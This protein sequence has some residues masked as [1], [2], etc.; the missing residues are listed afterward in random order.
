MNSLEE[1]G[2]VASQDT[3]IE[4]IKNRICKI[5]ETQVKQLISKPVSIVE[6]GLWNWFI[7]IFI[8]FFIVVII[9]NNEPNFTE[10]LSVASN[11]IKF[12]I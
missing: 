3:F 2:E 5:C 11:K 6:S 9:N 8:S 4:R 10:P 1:T 7:R 12:F